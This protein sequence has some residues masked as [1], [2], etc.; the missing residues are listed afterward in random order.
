MLDPHIRTTLCP[1]PDVPGQYGVA[2]RVPDR[3]G[4]FKFVVDY[5]RK[6]LV[7]QLFPPFSAIVFLLSPCELAT[8]THAHTCVYSTG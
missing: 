2:L 4:V 7:P 5:R 6:G 8:D 3:H 1:F